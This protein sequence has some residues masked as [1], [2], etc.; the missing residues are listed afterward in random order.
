MTMKATIEVTGLRTRFGPA[1]A[2]EGMSFTVLPGQVTGLVGPNSAGKST[3]MPVIL[4]LDAAGHLVVIGCGK[5]IA[6]TS[7]ADLIAAT[8]SGRVTLRTA[9]RQEA[10]TVL[11]RTGP[12]V[13]ATGRDTPG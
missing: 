11:R 10:M 2:L 4:G 6:D 3:T 7:M 1:V 5:V 13:T 12:T 9:A 8:S